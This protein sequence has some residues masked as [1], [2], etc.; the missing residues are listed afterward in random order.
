MRASDLAYSS[1]VVSGPFRVYLPSRSPKPIFKSRGLTQAV[2]IVIF[3]IFNLYP[4]R[5]MNKCSTYLEAHHLFQRPAF[6]GGPVQNHGFNCSTF[7]SDRSGRDL[8]ASASSSCRLRQSKQIQ[9][10]KNNVNQCVANR[11]KSD[12]DH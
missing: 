12:C 1:C 10:E 8:M 11:R 2:L 3:T 6:V 5:M 7:T 4:P 9:N